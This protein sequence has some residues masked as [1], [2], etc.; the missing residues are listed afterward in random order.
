M[1]APVT[2]LPNNTTLRSAEILA[3][4]ICYFGTYSLGYKAPSV[5]LMPSPFTDVE[6]LLLSLEACGEGNSRR[7]RWLPATGIIEAQTE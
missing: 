2:S 4:V 6:A 5:L 7:G 1:A 3:G